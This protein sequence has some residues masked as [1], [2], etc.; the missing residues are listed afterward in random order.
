MG[1]CSSDAR[2]GGI[3]QVRRELP[4]P[5]QYRTWQQSAAGGTLTEQPGEEK[6]TLRVSDM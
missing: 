2:A 4:T 6:L 3:A 5:C 1:G